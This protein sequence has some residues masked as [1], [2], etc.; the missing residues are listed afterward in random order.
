MSTQHAAEWRTAH[1]M[2]GS[3]ACAK[4]MADSA[5]SR[6]VFL[7]Q[8]P[9]VQVIASC[10]G[11][12]EGHGAQP[13]LIVMDVAAADDQT[14]LALQEAIAARW[15]AATA[16]RTTGSLVSLEFGCAAVRTC[17]SHS[18]RMRSRQQQCSETASACRGRGSPRHVPVRG[19]GLR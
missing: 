17:V 15:A 2:H 8:A 11:E 10:V 3:A 12:P 6:T 16:E 1:V 5:T 13:G 14:A 9:L 4:A 7:P 18:T 19:L